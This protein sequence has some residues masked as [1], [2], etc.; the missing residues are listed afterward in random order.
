M[1]LLCQIMFPIILP[2]MSNLSYY[3]SY[4]VKLCHLYFL[5]F[6][7]I[8]GCQRPVHRSWQTH[9]L[10]LCT[11]KGLTSDTEGQQCFRM[12]RAAGLVKISPWVQPSHHYYALFFLLYS[13]FRKSEQDQAADFLD[14]C[15]AGQCTMNSC[16][17]LSNSI[18]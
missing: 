15:S 1:S 16:D 10:V 13:L 12:N 9:K 6:S 3:F 2:I 5:L 17:T 8:P 11:E 14:L 18:K 7:I 4:Y